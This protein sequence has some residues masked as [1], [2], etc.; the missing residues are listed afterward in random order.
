MRIWPAL[1][2]T[3]A[4]LFSSV[5]AQAFCQYQGTLYAKTT[6]EQEYRDARWVVRARVVR[7]QAY[8]SEAC[9]DCPGRL[10]NLEVVHR[11]KGDIAQ[12]FS[13]YTQQNSGGF[14]LDQGADAIG[15]EWLLF[16]NPGPWGVN[17]PP[18]ARSAAW[19]NYS[20]GQSKKWNAVDSRQRAELMRLASSR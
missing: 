1:F 19:I 17:D 20:C 6:L 9:H 5:P 8:D 4:L 13:F 15:S 14:Y 10:Y 2:A 16:L 11:Y 3:I 7:E 18:A 12:K